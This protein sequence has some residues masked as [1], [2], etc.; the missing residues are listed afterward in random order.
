MASEI[1]LRPTGGVDEAGDP[2]YLRVMTAEEVRERA[3]ENAANTSERLRA[4]A[5]AALDG[6][7]T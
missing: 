7:P 6:R 3:A 2:V 1:P 5:L 4:K